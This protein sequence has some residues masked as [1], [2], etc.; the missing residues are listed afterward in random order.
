MITERSTDFDKIKIKVVLGEKVDVTFITTGGSFKFSSFGLTDD[1]HRKISDAFREF[2]EDKMIKL[3]P[4]L[5][6][7]KIENFAINARSK[8][9]FLVHFTANNLHLSSQ[10]VPVPDAPKRQS[11]RIAGRGTNSQQTPKKETVRNIMDRIKK[12]RASAPSKAAAKY[13]YPEGMSQEDKR[14]FRAKARAEARKQA[15]D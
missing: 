10:S 14:R 3:P 7:N 12:E 2:V 5:K 9:D 4:S 13:V 15:A 1:Q 6:F 11:N 8:P